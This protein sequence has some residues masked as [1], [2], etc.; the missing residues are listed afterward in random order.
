MVGWYGYD[1]VAWDR[2]CRDRG[3]TL[4]LTDSDRRYHGMPLW[5]WGNMSTES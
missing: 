1:G 4:A 5:G 3:Q 2:V